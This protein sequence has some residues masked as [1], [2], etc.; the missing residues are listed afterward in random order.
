MFLKLG[1]RNGG[2]R[3]E[4]K[5]NRVTSIVKSYSTDSPSILLRF[6][7]NNRPRERRSLTWTFVGSFGQYPGVDLPLQLVLAMHVPVF[8]LVVTVQDLPP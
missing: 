4:K 5:R 2:W 3:L 6:G 8:P 1:R 7:D